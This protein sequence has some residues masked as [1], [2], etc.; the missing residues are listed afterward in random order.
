MDKVFI[1]DLLV[2]TIIG[3]HDWERKAIQDVL[4]NVA[5]FTNKRPA[6]AEDDIQVCVDYSELAKEIR[7]L[8]EASRRFTVEAL[9]EDIARK[10]LETPGVKKVTVRVEKPRAVTEASSVGVEIERSK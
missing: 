8:V 7:D 6:F 2:K 1:K 10:C 5:V 3:I 4:I 9:A